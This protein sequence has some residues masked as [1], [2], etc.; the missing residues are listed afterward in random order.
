ME[1]TLTYA[2][3]LIEAQQREL[4]KGVL[5]ENPLPKE[6]KEYRVSFKE[7]WDGDPTV[8]IDLLVDVN[9]KGSLPKKKLLKLAAYAR[10]VAAE[11]LEQH[12]PYWPMVRLQPTK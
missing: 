2:P 12:I 4:I 10:D 7:D 8:W 9:A 11:L 1:R 3:T 6:V 5:T